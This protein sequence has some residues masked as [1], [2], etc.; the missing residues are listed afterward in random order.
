SGATA[1]LAR[2]AEFGMRRPGTAVTT[3]GFR[4]KAKGNTYRRAM[5]AAFAT[6]T[7]SCCG[8]ESFPVGGTCRRADVRISVRGSHEPGWQLALR[9]LRRN[10]L[11]RKQ[12]SMPAI[13][14]V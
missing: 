2:A 12:P 1:M 8:V 14:G 11:K 4:S 13:R 5:T 10:G 6:P 7:L 3:T 9:V